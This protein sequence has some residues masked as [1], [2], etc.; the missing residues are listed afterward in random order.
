MDAAEHYR[1]AEQ[2]LEG[3]CDYGCPHAGCPHE[4][5]YVAR[6]QAHAA[7]ALAALVGGKAVTE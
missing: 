1:E 2:L 5:V 7:L 3:G 4:V 6:A